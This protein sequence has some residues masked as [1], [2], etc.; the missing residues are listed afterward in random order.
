[1]PQRT[2]R[3]KFGDAFRGLY[4]GTRGQGSFAAH[5]LIAA[6]VIVAGFVFRVT[7][8][9]WC[10]LTI[11]IASVLAAEMFNCAIERLAKAITPEHNEH[12]GRALDMASAAVL[13][14][15]FGSVAIGLLI[16]LPH[17]MPR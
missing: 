12:V 9:E 2:W 15:A 11:C 7:V 8:I 4:D 14:T 13:I 3:A 6:A 16:F 5:F 1:M 10:V 17:L